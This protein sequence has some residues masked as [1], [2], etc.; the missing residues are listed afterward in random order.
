MAG[1]FVGDLFRGAFGDDALARVAAREG[2]WRQAG[3]R[4]DYPNLSLPVIEQVCR[5]TVW[6]F[7]TLLLATKNDMDDIATAIA[8]IQRAWT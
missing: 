1:I 2:A 4:I 8:K 6:I 5:D 7:Q 3:R